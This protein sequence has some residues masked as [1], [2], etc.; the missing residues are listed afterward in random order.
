ML[1]QTISNPIPNVISLL[2][3]EFGHTPLDQAVGKIV[4]QYGLEAV[5]AS[6]LAWRA[7]KKEPTTPDTSGPS[8]FVLSSSADLQLFLANRL[9]QRLGTGGSILFKETWKESITPAGRSVSRLA[10]SAHRTSAN[11]SGSSPKTGWP[12]PHTNSSTGAGT[13]GRDGGLNIQTAA[14]LASWPTTSTRD[15]KG[16]YQG[17]RMRDGKI[18]TDTL[19]VTAQLA[20]WPTPSA[21]KNT[22]NSK[23]PQRLKEGGVQTSLADAAWLTQVD[24]PARLTASGEM[25]T[26][27]SAGME[28]GGQLNP[29]HSRWLM[30]L[31][32][33]WDDSAPTAMPSSRKSRKK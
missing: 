19:D 4:A 26:G 3:S 25:L 11:D 15:S 33:A 29:A 9:K 18:S 1:Q 2:V 27:S 22:K 8:G 24:G 21:S 28:S 7:D 14:Q 13:Q 10:L 20:T 5:R 6:L 32:P 16:G 23:D 17:G 30:G 31:P 12:T